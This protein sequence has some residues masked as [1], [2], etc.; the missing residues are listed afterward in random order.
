MGYL[1][2]ADWLVLKNICDK[3]G[4]V[5]E[6]IIRRMVLEIEHL[7]GRLRFQESTSD[8]L[9]TANDVYK[10]QL[11]ELKEVKAQRDNL[12]YQLENTR[13]ALTAKDDELKDQAINVERLELL[14][15]NYD[16]LERLNKD[17]IRQHGEWQTRAINAEVMNERLEN[18]LRE[19]RE[20]RQDNN[21][22]KAVVNRVLAEM[23]K[24]TFTKD[25]VEQLSKELAH[26]GVVANVPQQ[27]SEIV[28]IVVVMQLKNGGFDISYPIGPYDNFSLS[29]QRGWRA[30][31]PDHDFKPNG[32]HRTCIKLW[33][34]PM[35]DYDDFEQG[36]PATPMR[37]VP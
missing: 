35:K 26:G 24:G 36:G 10:N 9:R 33:K 16:N 20:L 11:S 13:R 21:V 7:Q 28:Q 25:D 37:D 14:K 22:I 32:Q 4:S 15:E 1:H 12:Q 27:T 30:P 17:L 6:T 34:G 19:L 18:D 31:G 8:D 5:D 3:G 29:Q 23:K 2:N